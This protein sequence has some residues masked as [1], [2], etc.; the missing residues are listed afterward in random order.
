[1]TRMF[2]SEGNVGGARDGSTIPAFFRIYGYIKITEPKKLFILVN[3]AK[4]FKTIG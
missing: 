3:D 2:W 4:P 1:M